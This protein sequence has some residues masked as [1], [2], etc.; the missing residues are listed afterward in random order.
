M[1]LLEGNLQINIKVP[2]LLILKVRYFIGMSAGALGALGGLGRL[3]VG[4]STVVLVSNINEEVR[5]C[6]CAFGFPTDVVSEVCE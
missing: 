6:G 2:N 5:D 4:G 1:Y 3:A